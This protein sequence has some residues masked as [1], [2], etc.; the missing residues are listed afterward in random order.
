M[1]TKLLAVATS[2]LMAGTLLTACGGSPTIKIACQD[3]NTI[4]VTRVTNCGQ[5]GQWLTAAE[6]RFLD[7]IKAEV[8]GLLDT[9]DAATDTRTIIGTVE[10]GYLSCTKGNDIAGII[11]IDPSIANDIVISAQENS[12]CLPA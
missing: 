12:L 8:P 9:G 1:R 6:V 3:P 11:G 7:Q 5:R 4:S 2:A 10:A